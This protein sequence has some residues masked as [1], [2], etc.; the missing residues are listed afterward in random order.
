MNTRAEI[1]NRSVPLTE[2]QEGLWYAHDREPGCAGWNAGLYLELLGP[3]DLQAM[4]RAIWLTIL[5]TPAMSLRFVDSD[6]GPRQTAGP[7]LL[8]GFADLSMQP[9][10][11]AQALTLMHAD[12][13]RPL[14]LCSDPAAALT[15]FVI[16][17]KRHFIY[18]R[19][20][21]LAIDCYGMALIL[22]RIAAHY[23]ALTL[24][25]PRPQPF[26]PLSLASDEDA[27]YRNS[28]RR[29]LDRRWWHRQLVGTN[30]V[31]G[32]VHASI[33]YLRD[34]RHL[35]AR[36][37]GLL[38][39]FANT[40]ELRW[41]DVLRALTG[42]YLARQIGGAAMIGLPYPARKGRS[43]EGLPCTAANVLPY[44]LQPDEN[45]PLPEWLAHET[46]R[47]AKSRDHGLYR[48]ELLQQ[49][50][51]LP[52]MARLYGP[53]VKVQPF[54]KPPDFPDLRCHL[55][56]LGTGTVDDLTLTFRG[57]PPSGIVFDL[58]GHPALYSRDDLQSHGDRLEAFLI[59]ALQAD[60][61]A[62]VP[63]LAP[64]G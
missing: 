13:R 58:D 25:T 18:L 63:T 38:S 12:S 16:Q 43:I 37:T 64:A 42:A 48:S 28:A 22:D 35:P 2:A 55:H 8:P 46:A 33:D 11:K 30:P 54:E 7:S 47:M 17:P 34:R 29:L 5:D 57:D 27:V 4:S 32:T 24:G 56:A 52:E 62:A 21:H 1:P 60:R 51:G 49:E 53:V 61:L 14:Q 20:H 45:A 41:Q 19:T 50:L 44:H 15:L 39:E 10:P 36:L 40:N 59:A 9:D 26:D 6:D 23:T 3:L 31:T